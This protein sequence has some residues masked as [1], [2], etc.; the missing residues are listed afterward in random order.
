[1]S[2]LPPESRAALYAL[3]NYVDKKMSQLKHGAEAETERFRQAHYIYWCKLKLIPDPC[4]CD[5]GYERIVACFAKNLIMDC[6]SRS[7]TVQ[8]YA[9]SI[10]RLFEMRGFPI[11]ANVSDKDNMVPKIIHASERE[12]AIARRRS[13]ITIEMYVTMAKLA[14][15]SAADSADAVVFHFFL[16]K[17]AGFRLAEYAQTTQTKVD[18]F[19][20][21]SGNKVIKAFIPTDWKFYDGKGRLI[22]THSLDGLYSTVYKWAG[23][24]QES[25]YEQPKKLTITFRIQENRQNGQS[26]T[27]VTDDK[28]PHICPVR[29]AYKILL[30]VK[31]LGQSDTQPM[32]MFVN[33][34]GIVKYLTGSKISEVLQSVAKACHPDL[35][36]DEIMRFSSHSGRVWAIVILDEAGMLPD[37]IKS[38]LRWMGD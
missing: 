17:V 20:Y 11:P 27:F 22:T 25:I 37:F 35:T 30:Q 24:L 34:H 12:K 26:I 23:K 31:R 8:G 21:A 29:L 5:R 4:G 7:A 32:G 14:K 15:E 13:P 18:E 28:H 38:Q 19:D 10:T 6:N 9:T 36:R 3:G 33:K 2:F 1:L 16:I